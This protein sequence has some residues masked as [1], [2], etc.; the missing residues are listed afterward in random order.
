MRHLVPLL[1]AEH[2][3][4]AAGFRAEARLRG[5]AQRSA[6]NAAGDSEHVNVERH[7][8]ESPRSPRGMTKAGITERRANRSRG[9]RVGQWNREGR[10]RL[11]PL[12][13]TQPFKPC[14]V[15]ASRFRGMANGGHS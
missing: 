11:S 10:E 6:L 1:R 7:R 9:N 2:S 4:S 3:E 5:D 14:L 13:A 15:E 8:L 12:R